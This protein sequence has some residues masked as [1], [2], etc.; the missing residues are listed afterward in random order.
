LKTLK[1]SVLDVFTTVPFGGNP[2]AV[3]YEETNLPTE[4]M[5][6]IA[7]ELN[8][9]ETVFVQKAEN[10]N[11]QKRYRIFT[12]NV[13]LPMA[14]H[15]TVGTSYY[16]AQNNLIPTEEGENK[17]II[18]EQVGPISVSV[19]KKGTAISKVEM[20]Q[21]TPTFGDI[22]EDREAVAKL[23]SLSID[24]LDSSLPIQTVSSGV[25]FLYIPVRTLSAM[26][27]IFFQNDIWKKYFSENPNTKHIFVLCLETEELTSTVHSRMF[28]PAMGIP[29]DPATGGAS[30]PLGAYLV[31]YGL[32]QPE[33]SG[34]Y[35]IK[36]EQGFEMGRPSYI[37]I[38]IRKE[39]NKYTE[40]KISGTS[41]IMGAGE[42]YV[43]LDLV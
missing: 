14:G 3:F 2:L 1:Y 42:I 18:E 41:V 21:P 8:L 40:V 38:S 27:Q 20:I 35:F 26:K 30:G 10:T 32:V 5:Q 43:P 19:Y 25:P 22:F 33:S 34:T 36:S 29:E 39:S 16:L 17:W 6:K 7:K 11:H 37:D 28:A 13:E 4:T 15:P 23:L 24:D 9:S 12:P 31:E